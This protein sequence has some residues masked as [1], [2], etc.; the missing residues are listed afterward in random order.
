MVK[1]IPISKEYRMNHPKI[2]G[3]KRGPPRDKSKETAIIKMVD[4]GKTFEAA[5]SV[6]GISRQRAHQIYRRGTWQRET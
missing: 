4:E 2:F 3:K 5:G 1:I 6:F